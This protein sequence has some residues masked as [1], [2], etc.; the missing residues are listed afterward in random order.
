MTLR[1]SPPELGA[2]PWPLAPAW[3]IIRHID[4]R[5]IDGSERLLSVTKDRGVVPRDLLTDRPARADTLVGYKR[6][7]TGDLIINQMSIFDGLLGVSPCDGIVTYHYL[8]F[9]P[10]ASIDARFYSYLF[11][12]RP[13]LADF[14]RRVRGLGGYDQNNVRTPHIRIG[15]VG[16]TVVPVPTLAVQ[17]A[18][19]DYLDEEVNRIDSLIEKKRRIVD[20]LEERIECKIRH[21]IATSSLVS[22]G[23]DSSAIL[24]KRLLTKV[25]RPATSGGEVITA[26]RD[27]QVTARSARRTDGFTEA[28]NEEPKLQGVR[29]DDV[30]I[31]GLDG[32]AGAI[33][34]ADREGVCSPVYHVCVPTAKGDPVYLGR[35]LRIL[36]TSEYLGLFASSTRERAVDFRNW[37]LFGR[38]PVPCV[39]VEEQ[40]DIAKLIRRVAPLKEAVERSAALARE[41]RHALV[42]A[43]VKGELAIPGVAA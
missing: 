10:A 22:S 16:R 33:G 40:V 29:I 17:R 25:N 31:H 21:R 8:V 34:T 6:C 7:R 30:V 36:A 26:F 27:G 28:S 24:I 42:T 43:A 37:D 4:E 41:R 35:L 11:T 39:D 23:R 1:N 20:L 2:V 18:I 9:R 3:S 5:S 38:I 12:S 32:F 13:Y 19:A 15:D 14:A